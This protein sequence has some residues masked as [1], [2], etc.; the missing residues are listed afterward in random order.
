METNN[1]IKFQKGAIT[2]KN[3]ADRMVNKVVKKINKQLK[4]DVFGNRF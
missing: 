1:K 4:E 3:K 2:I